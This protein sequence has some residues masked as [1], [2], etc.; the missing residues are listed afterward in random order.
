MHHPP[1]CR[2]CLAGRGRRSGREG[3]PHGVAAAAHACRVQR[4]R[5][6]RGGSGPAAQHRATNRDHGEAWSGSSGPTP[7]TNMPVLPCCTHLTRPNNPALRHTSTPLPAQQL[8]CPTT[9]QLH[10][11][12]AELGLKLL[13]RAFRVLAPAATTTMLLKAGRERGKRRGRGEAAPT[14]ESVAP[15]VTKGG[16]A[17]ATHARSRG[18]IPP[19]L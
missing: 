3:W 16:T 12:D 1:P 6:R 15:A 2:G 18:A 10:K 5:R 11:V 9:H 4:C 8:E 7:P 17:A 13:G 19:T 14:K